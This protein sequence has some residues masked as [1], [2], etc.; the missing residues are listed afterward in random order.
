MLSLDVIDL[1]G[2]SSSSSRELQRADLPS[3]DV[4][5]SPCRDEG[6]TVGVQQG[7]GEF[8]QF[9]ADMTLG[10]QRLV[11]SARLQED[12]AVVERMERLLTFVSIGCSEEF[13]RCFEFG[14]WP[15]T[16]NLGMLEAW[17]L[18]EGVG[19]TRM[20][21]LWRQVE[22]AFREG[23]FELRRTQHMASTA[24]ALCVAPMTAWEE[25]AAR[26]QEV[27]ATLAQ[28]RAATNIL[29]ADNSTLVTQLEEERATKARMETQL[30]EE[31]ASRALLETRLA[32]AL[33]S[34]DRKEKEVLEAA[35]MVK[36]A[37]E[38]QMVAE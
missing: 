8:E 15:K 12:A 17:R 4:V 36:T 14:R 5:M 2:G 11:T 28:T 33:E 25:L 16:E 31:R 7:L 19:E 13:V 6:V 1:E 3:L 37:M 32:S 10:A 26:F 20:Q 38:R 23:Y 29:V 18:T 9:I 35:Y 34:I 24:E 27:E 30:E 22:Q 21:S